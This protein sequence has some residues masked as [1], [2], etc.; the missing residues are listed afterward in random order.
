M[1][2]LDGP[3]RF[4]PA[5]EGAPETLRDRV[6]AL[7]LEGLVA[8][9]AD[10]SYQA[11][12]RSGAWVKVK[13]GNRQEFVIGGFTPPRGSRRHL[14]AILAGYYQGRD[15]CFAGK[16]GSGFTASACRDLHAQLARLERDDCP[17]DD[18]KSTTRSA[19][20]LSR[21]ERK[22]CRWVEPRLVCE[23]KFAGWTR[24]GKLR[25]PVFI[26]LRDDKPAAKVIRER[27]PA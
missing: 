9:R 19:S 10:S 14:G 2:G 16:V 25:Q 4:S 21:A 23:V 7:G 5:L 1:S 12:Q 26:G 15:F 3:L 17:F 22:R 27:P 20:M 6:C 8:K 24:D 18:I 11:G 13:C